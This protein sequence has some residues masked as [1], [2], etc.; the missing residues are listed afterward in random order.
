ME[1]KA[2]I[3]LYKYSCPR[4]YGYHSGLKNLVVDNDTTDKDVIDMAQSKA[5]F[6]SGSKSCNIYL[7]QKFNAVIKPSQSY[8]DLVSI[9]FDTWNGVNKLISKNNNTD[10]E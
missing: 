3:F 5:N 4:W 6:D 9:P 10:N 1:L 8:S 7:L 2:N